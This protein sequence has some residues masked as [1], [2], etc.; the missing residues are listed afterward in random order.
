M[1]LR[2]LILN[3]SIAAALTPV[4]VS[5]VSAKSGVEPARSTVLAAAEAKSSPAA[6]PAQIQQVAHV[7]PTACKKVRVVHIG[8]GE[9][10]LSNCAS[11][12][13]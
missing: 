7:D 3:L 12:Q 1:K 6:Q 13:R 9:P 4:A 2:S 8:Y 5:I 10:V 11:L